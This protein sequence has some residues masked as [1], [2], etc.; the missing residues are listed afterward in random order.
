MTEQVLLPGDPPIELTLRPSARARRLSLRVSALDGRVTLTLPR[1]TRRREA[2]AFAED[3]A[4]WIRGHLGARPEVL[5]PMPGTELPFLGASHRIVAGP[6]RAV[7]P[8]DGVIHVPETRP[9]TTPARLAAFL[10]LRARD[11]L[12]EASARHAGALGRP[13]GQ[14]TL[15]DTRSRWGS[16]SSKGNLMFSWRLIMAP[17]E[18]LDYVAAHEVAHLAEMNHSAAFWRVVETLTPDHGAPRR[19]LRLNGAE[20]HRYRFRD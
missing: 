4:D 2:L 6:G 3:K 9:E 19:W 10:K 17:P 16:C 1:G 5:R 8:G 15:R 11:A 14:I 13:H 12:A 18:V 20:L 7:R